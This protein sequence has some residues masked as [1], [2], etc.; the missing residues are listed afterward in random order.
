MTR[1]QLLRPLAA[2]AAGAGLAVGIPA[3]PAVSNDS[4]PCI[5]PERLDQISRELDAL[6]AEIQPLKLELR[7][8]EQLRSE[9]RAIDAELAEIFDLVISFNPREE[10]IEFL[11]ELRARSQSLRERQT[12]LMTAAGEILARNNNLVERLVELERQRSM[13]LRELLSLELC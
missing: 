6:S 8:V 2:I 9:I 4:P 13:L 3:L 1:R 5:S 12:E 10:P 7:N 11:R